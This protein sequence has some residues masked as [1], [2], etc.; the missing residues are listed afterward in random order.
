MHKVTYCVDD[1]AIITTHSDTVVN[2]LRQSAREMLRLADHLEREH[3]SNDLTREHDRL[4]PVFDKITEGMVS[5]RDPIA[6]RITGD[7]VEDINTALDA[8][9]FFTATEPT[10]ERL[11]GSDD[12]L[13]TSEGYRAGPAGDH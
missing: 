12:F 2:G 1:G 9:R 8:I 13:I 5:W 11:P 3:A 7:S 10:V 6:Y 4:R